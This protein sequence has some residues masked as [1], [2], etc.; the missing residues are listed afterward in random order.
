MALVNEK[1]NDR[2]SPNNVT[3]DEHWMFDEPYADAG[4][5]VNTDKIMLFNE[6]NHKVAI[7]I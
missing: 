6:R 1:S 5:F 3:E 4:F 2:I 7:S